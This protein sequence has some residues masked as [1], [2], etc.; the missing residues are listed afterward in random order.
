MAFV[1][2]RKSQENKNNIIISENIIIEQF[3]NSTLINFLFQKLKSFQVIN[4]LSAL[5][6]KLLLSYSHLNSFYYSIAMCYWIKNLSKLIFN[7]V[8]VKKATRKK[9]FQILIMNMS[10]L[11]SAPLKNMIYLKLNANKGLFR[12]YCKSHAINSIKDY[13]LFIL[14]I[15]TTQ[16][17][18]KAIAFIHT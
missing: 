8:N 11:V 9:F 2:L 1:F 6:S 17:H 4:H 18:Q 3:H 7:Y 15:K 12:T 14:V 10:T 16:F 5:I 13:L